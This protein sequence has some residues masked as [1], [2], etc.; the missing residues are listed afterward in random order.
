M[1]STNIILIEQ[2]VKVAIITLRSN[3]PFIIS[4]LAKC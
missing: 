4:K 3:N 2:S 1:L